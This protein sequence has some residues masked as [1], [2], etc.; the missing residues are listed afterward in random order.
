[1]SA[2]GSRPASSVR[3]GLAS[4]KRTNRAGATANAVTTTT[5]HP[6]AILAEKDT[7]LLLPDARNSAQLVEEV[8]DEDNPILPGFDL[9]FHDPCQRETCAVRV[10]V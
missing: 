3:I 6:P 1:M 5:K 4:L 8:E 7:R 2:G 10:Q 9:G